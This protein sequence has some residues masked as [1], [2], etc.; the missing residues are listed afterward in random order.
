[1][2]ERHVPVPTPDGPMDT[3]I[4]QPDGAGPFR[5]VV[6]FQNVGGLSETMRI[7][8]RRVA[9]KG[10]L[11]AIPDLYFRLG[12]IVLDPDSKMPEVLQ[13]RQ[14]VL[15]TLKNERVMQDTRALLRYLDDD[16]KVKSGPKGTIGYCG[17]GRFCV[18]AAGT[19]PEHFAA[20]GSLFGTRFV[21][22]AADSPHIVLPRIRG[23]IYVGHAEHDHHITPA[24]QQEFNTLLKKCPVV[25]EIE[26]H[27]GTEHGYAFPG[28]VV[29]NQR[30]AER[31]W[32][33]IFTMFER[34]LP[35]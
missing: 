4:A 10:Y 19:F 28:R 32:E 17:G 26:T 11:C 33:R 14:I 23:E 3:F 2:Q 15:T 20:T 35:L 8:A 12:K 30:A 9:E 18:L 25:S 6:M 27:P 16:L 21:T 22:T 34:Q 13:I 7:M 1:M 29:Y 5:S 31:S 24:E